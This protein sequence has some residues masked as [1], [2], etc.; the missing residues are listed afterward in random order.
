MGEGDGRDL[1]AVL[2]SVGTHRCEAKLNSGGEVEKGGDTRVAGGAL[3]SIKYRKRKRF[4]LQGCGGSRGAGEGLSPGKRR[5][6]GGGL[7][8]GKR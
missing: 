5:V 2:R 3:C 6:G 4:A 8:P 1:N 7:S